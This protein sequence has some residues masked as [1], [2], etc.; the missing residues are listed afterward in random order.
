MGEKGVVKRHI[1][2]EQPKTI[3]MKI[4]VLAALVS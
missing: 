3:T 2:I 1:R 4:A